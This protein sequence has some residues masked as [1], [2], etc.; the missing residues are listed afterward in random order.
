[1]NY[2]LAWTLLGVPHRHWLVVDIVL[3]TRAPS[4]FG[5][6]GERGGRAT[7]LRKQR[8]GARPHRGRD[9]KGGELG[10]VGQ[11]L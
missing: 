3:E 7:T 2:F 8:G 11:S 1:M 4:Q 6:G 9:R 10:N 5:G